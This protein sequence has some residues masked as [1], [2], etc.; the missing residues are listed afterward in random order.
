M[1]VFFSVIVELINS[2]NSNPSSH[3]LTRGL[4]YHMHTR[5]HTTA[6]YKKWL[7]NSGRG[8]GEEEIQSG[9][10]FIYTSIH[11]HHLYA[12]IGHT[13]WG[14]CVRSPQTYTHRNLILYI[15]HAIWLLSCC[16]L[17][18]VFSFLRFQNEEGECGMLA[19]SGSACQCRISM[20]PFLTATITTNNWTANEDKWYDCRARP[21]SQSSIL[22]VPIQSHW[23]AFQPK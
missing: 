2:G 14:Q 23:S 13:L 22:V 5:A 4:V 21:S 3:M 15:W 6:S 9:S 1:L 17:Y 10:D 12:L 16:L 20:R 18:N 11:G 7:M 8:S 19:L